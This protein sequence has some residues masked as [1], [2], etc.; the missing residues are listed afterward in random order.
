M[1]PRQFRAWRAWHGYQ[2]KEVCE[3][4]GV[5]KQTLIAFEQHDQA[6]EK[7]RDA[8]ARLVDASSVGFRKDGCLILPS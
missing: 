3:M 1:T 8:L 7:T 6:S 5:S 4:V 2:S